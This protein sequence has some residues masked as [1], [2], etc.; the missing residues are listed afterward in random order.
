M[1]KTFWIHCGL[2]IGLSMGLCFPVL[3][4]ILRYDFGKSPLVNH[5]ILTKHPTPANWQWTAAPSRTFRTTQGYYWQP[6]AWHDGVVAPRLAWQ[7]ALPVGIYELQLF[8][9]TGLE[10]T[11]TWR[12]Y[13]NG[14]EHPL[15]LH[16]TRNSPEP[17][18]YP[19]KHVKI[20]RRT[21]VSDGNYTVALTGGADS[22]RLLAA[23]LFPVVKASSERARWLAGMLADY[24]SFRPHPIPLEPVL[25]NLK[26]A[27]AH[28]PDNAYYFKHLQ[29]AQWVDRAEE[30]IELR[31]W[32][33]S[34][35]LY[36]FT[37]IQK[38][39]QAVMLLN[40][41]LQQPDHPLYER[42]LW[43]AGR[44]LF[45]L[46]HEY[47]APGDSLIAQNYFHIL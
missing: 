21:F 5:P 34:T 41:I 17:L 43:D 30:F 29:E 46:D 26:S 24:G 11:S 12:I 32:Q 42:A 18:E 20:W 31:G 16:P 10:L 39:E 38:F 2:L 28:E 1:R 37:M 27:L 44:L 19:A 3:A 6:P 23:H 7:A 35:N 14:E 8:L 13:I 9:N 22:I 40:P 33:W 45:H 25:D 4:Q 15:N 47:H 36:E